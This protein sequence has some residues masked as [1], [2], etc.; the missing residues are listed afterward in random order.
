M[1]LG[2]VPNS[3]SRGFTI[4]HVRIDELSFP[5]LI[6]QMFDYIL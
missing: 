1:S 6:D 4:V 2:C 3:V 5:E